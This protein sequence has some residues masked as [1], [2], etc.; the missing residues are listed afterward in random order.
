MFLHTFKLKWMVKNKQECNSNSSCG[1]FHPKT[2]CTR[3]YR[4]GMWVKKTK[5][6]T[7]ECISITRFRYMT[8]SCPVILHLQLQCGWDAQQTAK[9][10]PSWSSC[11]G[12]SGKL[13]GKAHTLRRGGPRWGDGTKL[14]SAHWRGSSCERWVQWGVGRIYGSAP[15]ERHITAVRCRTH[16]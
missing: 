3:E 1:Q 7:N 15:V 5:I 6:I 8:C 4:S 10:P 14:R 2:T 16:G 9:P 11:P 12:K 13:A